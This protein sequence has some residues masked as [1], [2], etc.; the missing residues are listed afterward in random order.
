MSNTEPPQ[1]PA[2]APNE[3]L[4]ERYA[5]PVQVIESWLKIPANDYVQ[6]KISRADLDQ[7]FFALTNITGTHQALQDALVK[8]SNGEV[9]DANTFLDKSRRGN[10]IAENHIRRFFAGIMAGATPL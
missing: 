7:L 4:P 2:A 9:A 1:P 3:P 6:V 10:I 5:I 8:W